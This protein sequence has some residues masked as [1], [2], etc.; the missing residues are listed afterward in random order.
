MIDRQANQE[1]FYRVTLANAPFGQKLSLSC[2]WVDPNGNIVHQNNYQTK[3]IKTL[4]WNTFCRYTIG[5]SAPTGKWQDNC[6]PQVSN[7]IDKGEEKEH[8]WVY[9]KI[10]DVNCHR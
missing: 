7:V 9:I 6:S 1:V 8:I 5:S 10:Y 3:E 4:I 2:N